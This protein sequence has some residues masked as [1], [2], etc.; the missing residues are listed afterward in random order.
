M[1]PLAPY[2]SRMLC[3]V[4][5]VVSGYNPITGDTRRYEFDEGNIKGHI[6]FTIR[7]RS[8]P[9]G[10][11]MP[12]GLIWGSRLA[13]FSL[14]IWVALILA[15]PVGGWR[16]KLVYLFLGWLIVLAGQILGLYMQT[17][18]GKLAVLDKL[19]RQGEYHIT[20]TEQYLLIWEY[21]F[22]LRFGATLVPILT[23]MVIGLPRLI[24]PRK[25]EDIPP[26]NEG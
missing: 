3:A 23:W 11:R 17:M 18:L 9:S 5:N 20:K 7:T 26:Q 19:A 13:H 1:K 12:V 15:T 4:A 10:R 2:Y 14:P 16:R 25:R 6:E 22:S 8:Q 24:K 21:V